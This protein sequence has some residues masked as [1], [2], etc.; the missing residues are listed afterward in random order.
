MAEFGE[1]GFHFGIVIRILPPLVTRCDVVILTLIVFEAATVGSVG[2]ML[3]PVKVPEVAVRKIPDVFESRRV[4]VELK[5]RNS[6]VLVV[7]VESGLVN[8]C[9]FIWKNVPPAKAPVKVT[10]IVLVG[11]TPVQEIEIVGGSTIVQDKL[12]LAI[13][14]V[15][16]TII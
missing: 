13:E 10:V 16:G 11:A 14:V 12:P 2:V 6:N 1:F 4:P 3:A 5:V 7:I 15:G 8:P 9:M